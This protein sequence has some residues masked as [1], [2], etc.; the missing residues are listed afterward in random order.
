MPNTRPSVPICSQTKASVAADI[1]GDG[2]QDVV[3]FFVTGK[4]TALQETSTTQDVLD[5][6]QNREIDF[7]VY[8]HDS[9]A[10]ADAGGNATT[11]GPINSKI[12][13]LSKAD[14]VSAITPG[15]DGHVWAPMF[16]VTKGD[17]DGDGIDEIF[18]TVVNTVYILNVPTTPDGALTTVGELSFKTEVTSVATGDAD[19]DGKDELVVCERYNQCAFYDGYTNA[20]SSAFWYYTNT[21]T[22]VA[23]LAAGFGDF[24]GDGVDEF[25]IARGY[26]GNCAATAKASV[27]KVDITGINAVTG[28]ATGLSIGKPVTTALTTPS[29]EDAAMTCRNGGKED[30]WPL[31]VRAL[32]SLQSTLPKA[33]RRRLAPMPR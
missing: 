18:L 28:L 21:D 15:V 33:R 5:T 4:P 16:S 7:F 31:Q 24:D 1:D 3:V 26:N 13:Y 9:Q 12:S 27:Y 17:I 2:I 19:G 6:T 22:A 8:R 32:P 14:F 11:F 30:Y 25:V 10:A 20:D 23:M 29:S